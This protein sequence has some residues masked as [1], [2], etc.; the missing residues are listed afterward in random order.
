M[1]VN[2]DCETISIQSG[3]PIHQVL[4]EQG[5]RS[6][7]AEEHWPRPTVYGE[8]TGLAP[9]T[10]DL[11]SSERGDLLTEFAKEIGRVIQFPPS[12]VFL[13]GLGVVA[14]AMTKSFKYQYKDKQ[15]KKPKPIN[16]YVVTAQPPSTG[17]SGANEFLSDPVIEAYDELNESTQRE[18]ARLSYKLNKAQNGLKNPKLDENDVDDKLME[19][20]RLEKRLAEIPHYNYFIDDTTIEAAEMVAS[21]QGGMFNIISAEAE[22]INVVTGVVYGGDDGG[23]KKA[24][25]NLL[26]KAWDGEKAS[27]KRRSR[28]G[29]TGNVRASIAVIAQYDSVDTILAAGASG[30]GLA[31]RFLLLSEPN[32]LGKRKHGDDLD[33]NMRLLK[34]YE[35]LI[36]NIVMEDE[37]VFT[38][39]SLAKSQINVLRRKIEKEMGEGGRYDSN[40]IIGF[41]GKADK[42]IYKI[43]CVLHAI[44]TWTD[45]GSRDTVVSFDAVSRAVVMFE[46]L[47]N[48]YVNA[49]D[50]MGHTGTTSEIKK[51][52]E[53]LTDYKSKGKKKVSIESFFQN[54]K[55]TKPFKGVMNLRK[56]LTDNI[57]PTLQD[58]GYCVISQGMV[59]INPKL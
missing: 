3:K 36:K 57:F 32:L 39:D 16:L 17:K 1:P 15:G 24:N 19:I 6:W 9:I 11:V 42:Q 44:D 30:R 25:F 38:F 49:A 8:E 29:F 41:V 47:S 59:F 34:T 21:E 13:H 31:E 51:A 37:V 35:G 22:S 50:V 58:L 4:C 18:R 43:A 33:F 48:A 54:N 55:S 23:S 45:G 52:I 5:V 2:T 28:D 7:D 26:L 53:R 56:K 12:T 14:S 46:S 10:I 40:M 20:H 27:S